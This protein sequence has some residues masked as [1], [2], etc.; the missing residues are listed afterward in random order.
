VFETEDNTTI[1]TEFSR[2]N[3]SENL[4]VSDAEGEYF[5][6]SANLPSFSPSTESRLGSIESS[7]QFLQLQNMLRTLTAAERVALD[8]SYAEEAS[9][10]TMK[11]KEIAGSLQKIIDENP[12]SVGS[13]AGNEEMEM[14]KIFD[15]SAIQDEG[16]LHVCIL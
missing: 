14:E 6:S 8:H 13:M 10:E 2:V 3:I 1:F 15:Y 5:R 9:K 4:Y 16:S 7:E 11:E 12:E